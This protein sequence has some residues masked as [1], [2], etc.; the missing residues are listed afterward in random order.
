MD[1]SPKEEQRGTR[2]VVLFGA[3]IAFALGVGLG[4]TFFILAIAGN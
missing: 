4:V 2:R 3:V 1:M